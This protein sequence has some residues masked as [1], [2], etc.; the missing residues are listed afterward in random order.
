MAKKVDVSF[1]R[2]VS[3]EIDWTREVKDAGPKLL[4]SEHAC[5]SSPS[6]FGTEFL[7]HQRWDRSPPHAPS[8]M[9][10]VVDVYDDA[11]GPCEMLAGHLSN[12]YFDM[13][14]KYAMK[15]VRAVSNNIGELKAQSGNS[16]PMFLFYLVRHRV[17]RAPTCHASSAAWQPAALVASLLMLHLVCGTWQDG[18]EVATVSGADIPAIRDAIEANAPAA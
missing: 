2:L 6:E 13:G 9:C 10:A 3:S 8:T 12:Y 14:E 4:C 17:S 7:P 5:S 18:A 11:W 16:Q 1:M 15:F